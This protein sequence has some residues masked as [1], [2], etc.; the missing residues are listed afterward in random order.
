MTATEQSPQIDMSRDF[1]IVVSVSLQIIKL[2]K[3]MAFNPF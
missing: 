3:K 1:K 2:V